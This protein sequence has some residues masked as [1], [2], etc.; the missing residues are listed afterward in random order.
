MV[1]KHMLGR[2]EYSDETSNK[3]WKIVESKRPGHYEATWGRIGTAGQGQT[4]YEAIQ[5]QKKIN[6]KISKGYL[7]VGGGKTGKAEVSGPGFDFMA[8]LKKVT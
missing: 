5:A 2:Y 6:E 4:V 1:P 8:E 7:L 3:F